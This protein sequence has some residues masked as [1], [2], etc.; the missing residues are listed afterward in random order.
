M[1]APDVMAGVM[2]YGDTPEHPAFQLT[3]QVN[4]IS[5]TGGSELTRFVGSEGIIDIEG[6]DITVKHSL[7]PEAPGFGGYDS[8]FTF[9][10]SMQT[11]MQQE[12][13]TINA[14]NFCNCFQ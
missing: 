12:Y 5:G 4:F 9:A 2:Q 10:K 3:L 14:G 11:E 1:N 6:N 7:M 8:V 13:G